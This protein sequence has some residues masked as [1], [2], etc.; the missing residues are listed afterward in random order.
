MKRIVPAAG[1]TLLELLVTL[2]IVAGVIAVVLAC[3]EGGFRVYARIR[4]FG[5]READVYLAGEML[6]RDIGHLIPS[7][8]YRFQSREL[9]FS[10]APFF[11]GN[12]EVVQVRAPESGGLL[13]WSGDER[14]A[15]VGPMGVAVISDDLEVT[16][17]YAGSENTDVWLPAWEAATNLPSAVR[18]TVRGQDAD[19]SMLIERTMVLTSMP[20]EEGNE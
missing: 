2:T 12:V 18:M 9:F 20:F 19:G 14:A 16:F 6:E 1:F 10:R 11:D 4:D 17:S 5:I 7:A 15:V 3:F 13:Y 8:E